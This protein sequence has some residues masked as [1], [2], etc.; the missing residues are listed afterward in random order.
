V[1]TCISQVVH[2]E[3][4]VLF[5]LAAAVEDWPRIL[6]HYRRVVVLTGSERSRI[7]EMAAR[8]DIVLGLAFPLWWQATQTVDREHWHIDFDHIA[9]PTRGMHVEWRFNLM[10]ARGVE[11]TIRHQFAPRWPVPSRLVD[12]IVGEYFV[13]G[14]ARRTLRRIAYLARGEPTTIRGGSTG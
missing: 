4:E 12:L 11:V 13:N 1:D 9:G 10:D 7:V 2:A 5:R 3:P 6:P 8:R 14:V